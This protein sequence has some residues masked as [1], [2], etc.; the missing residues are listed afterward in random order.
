M[1]TD[2]ICCPFPDINLEKMKLLDASKATMLHICYQVTITYRLNCYTNI[3][4]IAMIPNDTQNWLIRT[5][6]KTKTSSLGHIFY[7]LNNIN[8]NEDRP[9]QH[10][11]H[12]TISGE[13]V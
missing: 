9:F 11:R 6:M 10:H 1:S 12:E 8:L 5:E 4:I 13:A 2:F 7:C 3:G